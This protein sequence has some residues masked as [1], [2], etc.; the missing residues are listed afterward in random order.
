MTFFLLIYQI[1]CNS[2][3]KCV[4][5]CEFSSENFSAV[6][7]HACMKTL[8]YYEGEHTPRC[9]QLVWVNKTKPIKENTKIDVTVTEEKQCLKEK[10]TFCDVWSSTHQCERFL[11]ECLNRSVIFLFWLC[12]FVALVHL[13]SCPHCICHC[14]QFLGEGGEVLC[15]EVLKERSSVLEDA[16]WASTKHF[17]CHLL[18]S[19]FSA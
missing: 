17:L 10:I 8:L 18:P 7:R 5:S 4:V 16:I 13:L 2:R 15:G 14:P 9:T 3:D 12:F 19:P 6:F 11:M 1:K